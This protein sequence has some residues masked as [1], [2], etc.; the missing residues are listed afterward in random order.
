ML[1]PWFKE[2]NWDLLVQKKVNHYLYY[3]LPTPYKPKVTGEQWL[4]GFDKDFTS[5]GINNL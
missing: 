1:H 4:D 2:M 3:K 5:E